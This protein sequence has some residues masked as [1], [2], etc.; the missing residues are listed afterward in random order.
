[1]ISFTVRSVHGI[2]AISMLGLNSML[3]YTSRFASIWNVDIAQGQVYFI[4]GK[5]TVSKQDVCRQ[6][7]NGIVSLCWLAL[8]SGHRFGVSCFRSKIIV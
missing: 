3:T 1:M 4:F 5:V 6:T 7:E 8:V 2:S